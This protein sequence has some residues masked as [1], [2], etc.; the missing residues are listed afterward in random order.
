MSNL[1]ALFEYN[2]YVTLGP[3]WSRVWFDGFSVGVTERGPKMGHYKQEEVNQQ[4]EI[5][6]LVSW[7]RYHRDILPGP[8][9]QL[10][11]E[12]D[13]L[14]Q[15]SIEA[16]EAMPFAPKPASSH[17]AL[18]SPEHPVVLTRNHIRGERAVARLQRRRN[19]S[20]VGWLLV[21]ASIVTGMVVL[22][23]AV[24]A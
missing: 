3:E 22:T 9:M 20:I 23:V 19:W 12:N 10:L 15:Q 2:S 17:V 11:L 14:L 4:A 16:W 1:S 8:Y 24:W 13:D 6:R 7:Y 5:D 18:Q 21:V